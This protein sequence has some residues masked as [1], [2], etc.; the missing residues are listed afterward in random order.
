MGTAT[1]LAG[2]EGQERV[3]FGEV[4]KSRLDTHHG[5]TGGNTAYADGHVEW[6]HTRGYALYYTADGG[7]FLPKGKATYAGWFWMYLDGGHYWDGSSFICKKDAA[8]DWL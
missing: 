3:L 8:D 6:T 2:Y 5:G 4:V 7:Y 1:A